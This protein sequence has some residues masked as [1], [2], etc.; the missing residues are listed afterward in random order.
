MLVFILLFMFSWICAQPMSMVLPGVVGFKLHGTLQ[1]GVTATDLVLTVTQMLRKHGVVGKFVEFYGIIFLGALT[2]IF[3]SHPK[4]LTV[5]LF[6]SLQPST[7]LNVGRGMAELALADRATIANMAPEYG[8]TAGFF[9]VDHATLEY[10]KMTGRKDE[11]VSI[12]LCLY[13][14]ILQH[15]FDNLM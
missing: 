12:M 11:T 6:F 5:I 8:A 10:L 14:V 13:S 3:S 9:P 4:I 15:L 2:A 1:S 7:N